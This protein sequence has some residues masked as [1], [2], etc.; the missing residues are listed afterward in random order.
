VQ[1]SAREDGLI[2]YDALLSRAGQ[3]SA[4]QS[5]SISR[6]SRRLAALPGPADMLHGSP[7]C[8]RQAARSAVLV[9]GSRYW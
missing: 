3:R 4:R 9:N 8:D 5:V 6:G 7:G 1:N 2:R